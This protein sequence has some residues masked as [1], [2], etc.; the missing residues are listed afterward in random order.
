MNKSIW[1]NRGNKQH[2]YARRLHN[3]SNHLT[4]E[5]LLWSKLDMRMPTW[6]SV[7]I[8]EMPIRAYRREL[9]G[10]EDTTWA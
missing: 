4:T 5:W 10:H 1:L 2:C 7:G 3:A 9:Q 6:P 8:M